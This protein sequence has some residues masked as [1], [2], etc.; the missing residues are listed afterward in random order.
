MGLAWETRPTWGPQSDPS[1]APCGAHKPI[2]AGNIQRHIQR[3]IKFIF[4]FLIFVV[5]LKRAIG[6][7]YHKMWYLGTFTTDAAGQ[8]DVLWHDG[9]TLGVDGAKVGI[10]E[11][12][13]EVSLRSLLE[14]HDG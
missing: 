12:T 2:L 11:E 7:I 10:L 9:D 3:H 4:L 1:F 14:G 13:D 5:A 6:F 8:L